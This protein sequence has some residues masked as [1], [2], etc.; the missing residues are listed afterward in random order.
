MKLLPLW[1]EATVKSPLVLLATIAVLMIGASDVLAYGQYSANKDSTNCRAC[2]GDFRASPYISLSDG[3]NW[4]DDLHDVHRNVMLAGDCSTCHGSG[5]RFP[6]LLDSSSGGVGLAA[7]SCVGCHGRD[8]DM[9]N[10]GTSAG[11]GAGLR[12][13]HTSAGV[14]ICSGCHSDAVLANYT[15]VGEDVL[16]NYYASPGTGH[17]SIPSDSCNPSGEEDFAG[18]ALGLDNDGD[19]TYDTSDANCV[20]PVELMKF[21]IE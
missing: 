11:R 18:T 6:V 8:A 15:P 2:H 12:Q 20:I 4:G 3:A 10:D 1:A 19:G 14:A 17:P 16:P 7:I 9:G 5:S 21:E 13:H